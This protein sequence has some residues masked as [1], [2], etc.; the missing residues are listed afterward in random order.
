MCSVVFSNDKQRDS[1][2]NFVFVGLSNGI[3]LEVNCTSG[4]IASKLKIRT[5]AHPVLCVDDQGRSILAV[6]EELTVRVFAKKSPGSSIS[7]LK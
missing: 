3:I 7:L 5:G 4:A 2:K 6:D 1:E